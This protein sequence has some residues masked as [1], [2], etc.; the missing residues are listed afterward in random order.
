[1]YP[2]KNFTYN[3]VS[4]LFGGNFMDLENPDKSYG[5]LGIRAF[6]AN[7]AYPVPGAFVTIRKKTDS[8]PVTVAVLETDESGNTPLIA[9]EAP[10][11]ALSLS[12][13]PESRPYALYDAEINKEGYYTVVARDVQVYPSITSILPV[14]M[15]PLPDTEESLQYPNNNIIL[16]DKNPN[17]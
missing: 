17:V 8:S 3:I 9:L 15:I 2:Y 14:N 1:M 5:K 11:K 6:S 12:P 10:P 7:S 13:N 16:N 4:F